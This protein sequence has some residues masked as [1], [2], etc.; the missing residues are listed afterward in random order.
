MILLLSILGIGYGVTMK[1]ADLF[2]EHGLKGFRYLDLIFGIAWGLFGASLVLL[3]GNE[4]ANII[5]AMNLAMI[6]RNR[7]DFLN[8]QIAV[9]LI[10][11]AYLYTSFFEP[12]IFLTFLAVFFV[13]GALRDYVGEKLKIKKDWKFWLIE[14]MPYYFV[15]AFIYCLYRGHWEIFA[16]FA[17]Y[18]AAYLITKVIAARKGYQ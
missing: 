13:F 14:S 10:V 12:G 7:I 1:V 4:M 18:A 9:V 5:L 15:P 17:A 16:A 11:L 8:H 6:P 3:G 2:N